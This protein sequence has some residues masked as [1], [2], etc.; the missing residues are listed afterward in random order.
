MRMCGREL[1]VGF[2]AMIGYGAL[3]SGERGQAA[4]EMFGLWGIGV[5]YLIAVIL[6]A[7]VI[8]RALRDA[9]ADID[10]EFGEE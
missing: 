4:W 9:R 3:M 7:R 8:R 10:R 5:S 1:L 2:L 6:A